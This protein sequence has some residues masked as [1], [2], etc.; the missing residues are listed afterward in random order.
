MPPNASLPTQLRVRSRSSDEKAM[1]VTQELREEW[2]P[3][4]PGFTQREYSDSE[5]EEDE[6]NLNDI[7]QCGNSHYSK[8]FNVE[9]L[10]TQ[11]NVLC[12][13]PYNKCTALAVLS[14]EL[15]Y[16]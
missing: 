1:T 6:D 4:D 15:I 16:V 3:P 8:I 7:A 14:K 10:I 11:D 5:L 2:S 13:I 12:G 9:I